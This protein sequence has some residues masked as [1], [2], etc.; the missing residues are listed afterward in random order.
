VNLVQTLGVDI[1]VRTAGSPAAERA[2]NAIADTFRELGLDPVF[3][4]FTFLGY[5]PEEPELEVEGERWAAGPSVFSPPTADGGA[6]GSVRYLG[7]FPAI[8]DVFEIPVFAIEDGPNEVARLFGNAIEGGGAIPFPGGYSP[9]LTEP[10]AIISF[11]DAQRLRGLDGAHARLRAGGEFRP[12]LRDCNVLAE[13]PGESEETVVVS[14]HFDSVW[15]GPGTIDNATGVEGVRRLAE[16]LVGQRHPRTL[17]FAAFGAEELNLFGSHYYVYEAKL[18]GT[19]DRVVGVVNLDCIAHGTRLEVMVGPDEL[20][21]RAIEH[22]RVLGLAERY[23]LNIMPPFTGTDHFP[24]TEE[25]IPGV[26]VL[27][28]PYP[29]YHQPDER[30]EL[31]DEQ[32]MDDAVE[33]ALALVETQLEQPVPRA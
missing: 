13:L 7:D 15:R 4:R 23:D 11:A 21:G 19:L 16:R 28:F 17:L 24:F 6:E 31:V 3:Q 22:A 26:S 18:H 33:L 10:S 32:K 8:P 14:A 25:K 12:G 20:R 30:L 27:H 29:E 9:A 2:A 5:E 1:G